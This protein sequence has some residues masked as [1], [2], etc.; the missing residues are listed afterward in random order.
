MRIGRM[1]RQLTEVG[2]EPVIGA[3]AASAGRTGNRLRR[4]V[5]KATLAGLVAT[6]GVLLPTSVA[7]AHGAATLPGSRTYLCYTDGHWTGG[8]LQPRNSAC[9]NAVA[10]GGKQPLWDW[11]GVLRGDGAGRM[12]GFI[13][14]GQLCSGGNPKYAAYDTASADWPATHLTSGA[15][16]SFHYNAWAPHPGVFSLYVT[17]DGYDPTKPLKWSDLEASPFSTW[18][19]TTPNGN[20]EY[21]W[22]TTLPAGK[23]GRHII[24][25][26]WSRTDS[27]ETFYNCSDVVFD[28]GN[29]QVTGFPSDNTPPTSTPTAMPSASPSST[30]APTPTRSTAAP[31]PSPTVVP[32]T[33]APVPTGSTPPGS[34]GCTGQV[35]VRSWPGGY[36]ATVTVLNRGAATSPW[37]ISLGVPAGSRLVTG[38]NADVSLSGNTVTAKAPAWN[39]TLATNAETSIGFVASGSAA[40]APAHLALNGIACVVD[41]T[42]APST[43]PATTIPP[44]TTTSTAATTSPVPSTPGTPTVTTSAPAPVPS[45]TSVAPS[46]TATAA[47]C[48]GASVACDG[49]ESQAGSAPSGVWSVSY[50]DC[51]G[52]GTATIDSTV[53]HSGGKSLRIDGTAGYC[54]H[55]FV[56]LGKD[57]A[58]V[59]GPLYVRAYVRH[60]TELPAG[61]VTFIAM[62]DAADGGKDLRIG[63]QNGALQWNRQ[64]D[65]ATLPEQSPAGVALSK[66]LPTGSWQCLEYTVNGTAGTAGTWLNGSA[67]A[68]LTAD[69][70]KTTNVDGQWYSR[71]W[72][73]ALTDLRFGWESYGGGSDTLWFDDIAVSSAPIGCQ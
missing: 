68:G 25:S 55:V 54:N 34:S 2:P 40:P 26:V 23:K 58:G 65:D 66:P 18:T 71:S 6:A 45:A 47:G 42:P 62:R 60:S 43:P 67:V 33:S 61:H 4:A 37:A 3:V 14:D 72:H 1:S 35:S 39:R 32:S 16:W 59:S 44:A 48:T 10:L 63:G 5:A 7:M 38:W 17:R 64:S 19:E 9:Q 50:P 31:S 28:G 73:P 70:T 22:K 8:D 13:P 11:F 29:G 12:A 53:A 24:Y 57:L 46:P 69:G 51:Q 21:Y 49:F 20:G 52:T 27:K 30:P 36:L 15:G 56:K 41:G